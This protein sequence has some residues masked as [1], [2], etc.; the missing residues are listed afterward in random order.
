MFHAS[1]PPVAVVI[2]WGLALAVETPEGSTS[3][4]VPGTLTPTPSV[5]A[6]PP[7]IRVGCAVWVNCG[8]VIEYTTASGTGV[9]A[10]AV[11]CIGTPFWAVKLAVRF[12]VKLPAAAM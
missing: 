9:P 3:V 2:V 12:Q 1:V 11:T 4:Y 7:A 6:G 5:P 10:S 8:G